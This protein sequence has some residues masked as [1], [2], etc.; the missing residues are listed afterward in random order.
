MD[1]YEMVEM[2]V[3]FMCAAAVCIVFM[4]LRAKVKIARASTIDRDYV[5]QLLQDLLQDHDDIKAELTDIQ[6]KV[7][8]IEKMMKD[9]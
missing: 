3:V 6:E 8:S 1:W 2:I 9:V 5:D 4:I 7:S